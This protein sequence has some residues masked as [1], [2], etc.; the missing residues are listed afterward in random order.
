[1]ASTPRQ[2]ESK[3]LRLPAGG[4][5]RLVERLISSLEDQVD[6]DA[7]KLWVEEAER[8]LEEL[9]SGTVKGRPA[10]SVCR[11]IKTTLR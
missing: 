2:L 11:K 7:E 1:M 3:A 4:R 6:P 10:E 8:R 9:R 5:A